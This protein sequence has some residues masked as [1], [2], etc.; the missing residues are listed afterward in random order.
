MS[1]DEFLCNHVIHMQ[2]GLGKKTASLSFTLVSV[3]DSGTGT[4]VPI[5]IRPQV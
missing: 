3:P 1:R 4:L 5:H 2:V